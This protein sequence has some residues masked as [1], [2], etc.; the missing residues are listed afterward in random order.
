MSPV[1][2]SEMS[3]IKN[4]KFA[5]FKPYSEGATRELSYPFTCAAMTKSRR[6]AVILVC[7]EEKRAEH[8]S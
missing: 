4:W 5:Y 6:K 8:A 7:G 2:A 1:Q 3:A